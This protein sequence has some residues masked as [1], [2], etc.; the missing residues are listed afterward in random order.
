MTSPCSP[1]LG[2]LDTHLAVKGF[3]SLTNHPWD[4]QGRPQSQ[5]HTGQRRTRAEM[6]EKGHLVTPD[7]GQL[8]EHGYRKQTYCAWDP[9]KVRFQQAHP[10]ALS[11]SLLPESLTHRF[12]AAGNKTG[13]Q[14]WDTPR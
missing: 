13:L 4:S 12:L 7:T 5:T 2:I 10:G 1:H 9:S 8:T 6:E 11:R 3:H 14:S